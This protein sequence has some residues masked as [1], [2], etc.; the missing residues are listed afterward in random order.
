V[1]GARITASFDDKDLVRGLRALRAMAIDSVPLMR[2]IG[3][4]LVE[5]TQARFDT[6]TDPSGH[7]WKALNPA[8]AALKR[9]PGILRESGMRGGLQGSITFRAARGQVE[10]GTN[11]VYGAVHQFGATIKPKNAKA[12]VFRLGA[13]GKM[14]RAKSVTIPARPYL[15][16]GAADRGGVEDV[17]AGALKRATQGRSA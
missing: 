12:L 1:T 17:V 15:G 2:A 6:A 10:V 14:V 9:G 8:Y 4:A 7:P 3:V 16:F 13:G 11:K 5:T